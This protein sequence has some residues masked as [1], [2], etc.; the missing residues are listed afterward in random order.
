MNKAFRAVLTLLL[1]AALCCPA[2][3]LGE[4]P[5]LTRDGPDQSDQAAEPAGREILIPLDQEVMAPIDER[6]YTGE[7]SY[8]DPTLSISIT[9][10]R[11]YETDYLVARIRIANPT[12]L[13]AGTHGRRGNGKAY[14]DNIARRLNAVLAVNGDNF[15]YNKPGNPKKYIVRNQQEWLVE[16]W[17]ERCYYDILLIDA[18][19]DLAIL[20]NPTRAEVDAYMAEHQILH[21]YCF[22]PALVINGERQPK[23]EES[24]KANGVGWTRAAQRV[25]LCQTGPLEYMIVV[26]AG[27]NNPKSTGMTIDQFLDVVIAEGSP[28]TAYNLDGGS[29]AWLVFRGA[30][31]NV[32]GNNKSSNRAQ[33]SDIIYFASAWSEE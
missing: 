1:I 18:N 22:G 32:F 33:I 26:S 23:P 19:A 2:L 16:N 3:S 27:P 4:D 31:Q 15:R 30:K 25:A 9:P 10:G 29:S 14:A 28:I 24:L 5:A 11:D 20:K 6:F 13:R 8:E 21:T 17:R 12:Q 7:L